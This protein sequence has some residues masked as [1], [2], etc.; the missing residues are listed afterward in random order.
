LVSSYSNDGPV[1]I[2]RLFDDWRYDHAEGRTACA[3][4]CLDAERTSTRSLDGDYAAFFIQRRG[5]DMTGV[6]GSISKA[7]IDPFITPPGWSFTAAIVHI[8]ET[9]EAGH[10]VTYARFGDLWMLFDDATTTT[11][12]HETVRRATQHAV[13]LSFDINLPCPRLKTDTS[14]DVKFLA[15]DPTPTAVTVTPKSSEPAAKRDKLLNGMRVTCRRAPERVLRAGCPNSSRIDVTR[16][17][18]IGG[19]LTRT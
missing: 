8:G 9:V 2:S 12:S 19:R 6:S 3:N 15:A 17:Y 1:S 18:C 5:T 14:H 10:Y 7:T 16:W 4:G 13:L 11:V